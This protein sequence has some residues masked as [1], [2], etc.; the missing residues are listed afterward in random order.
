MNMSAFGEIDGVPVIEV[1][2]ASKAGAVAKI[3]TWGA[4]LRDL[5]V[6]A[7][8]GPPPGGLGH[9]NQADYKAP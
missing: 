2:I 5:V 9:K 1:T 3:L 6:P 7:R 4:V 8:A